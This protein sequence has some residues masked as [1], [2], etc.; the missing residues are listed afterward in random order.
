MRCLYILQEE[1]KPPGRT[2]P[3][4]VQNKDTNRKPWERNNPA[5]VANRTKVNGVPDGSSS[6]KI[7]RV[8]RRGSMQNGNDSDLEKM[9]QEI[10]T[11]MRKEMQKL[12]VEIID[13]YINFELSV[14]PTP[15][16]ISDL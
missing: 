12:K 16:V 6:P 13:A 15:L 11:E 5:P 9:K 8:A 2:S 4:P 3:P 7:S 1:A 14:N 10:L